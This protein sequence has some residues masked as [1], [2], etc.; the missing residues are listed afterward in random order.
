MASAKGCD[1]SR[2]LDRVVQ[3]ESHNQIL[4]SDIQ[5]LLVKIADVT[6]RLGAVEAHCDTLSHVAPTRR[7][8]KDGKRDGSTRS[9]SGQAGAD[10][11]EVK[12]SRR[13]LSAK[14]SVAHREDTGAGKGRNENGESKRCDECGFVS[15]R[16]KFSKKQWNRTAGICKFYSVVILAVDC[17]IHTPLCIVV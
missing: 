12:D 11:A 7:G 8:Q 15:P 14:G 4:R 16:S 1:G 3:L 2:N 13:N 6:R 9:K 17:I 10:A 5:S